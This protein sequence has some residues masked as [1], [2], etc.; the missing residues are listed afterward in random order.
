VE[1]TLFTLAFILGYITCKTFYFYKS[2]RTSIIALK[3]THVTALAVLAKSLED[4]YYTKIY[5][6][7]KMLEAGETDHNISA[8]SFLM[9]EEISHY[10]KKS[11]E[12]LI[13]AHP[14]FFKQTIEFKDWDSAMTFLQTH[15]DLAAQFLMRS[16]DD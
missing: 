14:D 12:T 6:M 2:A 3:V 7:E 15:K 4:F 1:W 13:H 5:R 10:K 11:I 9:E 16:K 8:F